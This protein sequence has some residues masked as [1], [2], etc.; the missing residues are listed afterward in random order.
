MK[1]VCAWCDSLIR[2]GSP[3]VSHGICAPCRNRFFRDKGV[4]LQSFIDSFPFP[5]LVMGSSLQPIAINKP[6]AEATHRPAEIH[7]DE[8]IGNVFEC[9]HSRLPEGCG[10][11]V[12]CSG[13][14]LRRTL[15]HT[16]E[17][18]EPSFNV[19]ATISTD[20]QDAAF[21]VSTLKADGRIF[22]KLDKAEP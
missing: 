8:T 18:G 2:E 6:G 17:S 5:V 3:P 10:R 22:V 21:Y 16:N 1:T 4:P 12:H 15:E 19:P 9:E 11:T 20:T 14:V 13:C 7:C